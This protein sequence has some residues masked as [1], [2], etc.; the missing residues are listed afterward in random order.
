M[1]VRG[2]LET[3]PGETLPAV[4]QGLPGP[5]LRRKSGC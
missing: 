2:P 4:T 3:Q 1:L 5:T